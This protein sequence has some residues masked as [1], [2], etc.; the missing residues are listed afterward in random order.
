MCSLYS[1]LP[2]LY[3]W[4]VS[5]DVAP[6]HLALCRRHSSQA[7][8]TRFFGGVSFATE[9]PTPIP[10]PTL[11]L[12]LAL[13]LLPVLALALEG[14]RALMGYIGFIFLRSTEITWVAQVA[15]REFLSM[16]LRQSKPELGKRRL[17]LMSCVHKQTLEK[18]MR[19]AGRWKLR[20]AGRLIIHSAPCQNQCLARIVDCCTT[21]RAK[22]WYGV[23]IRRSFTT[24]LT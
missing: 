10:T 23:W 2:R 14:L 6:L 21:A 13:V 18:N 22:R 7:R 19:C 9:T 8:E 5:Q 12:A 1:C 17:I 3:L 11:E 16:N 4:Q 15:S 20:R 24:S